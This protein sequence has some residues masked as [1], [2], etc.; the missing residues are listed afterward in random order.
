[1]NNKSLGNYPILF[2][3]I[4]VMISPDIKAQEKFGKGYVF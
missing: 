1:M 2:L 4:M 3:L